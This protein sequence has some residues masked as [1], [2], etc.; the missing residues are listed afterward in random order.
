VHEATDQERADKIRGLSRDKATTLYNTFHT[1]PNFILP[2]YHYLF[3]VRTLYQ[4][5]KLDIGSLNCWIRSVEDAQQALIHHESQLQLH[6]S[7]FFALV[8]AAGH[9][10][11]SITTDSSDLDFTTQSHFS[12][13]DT[14]TTLDPAT[15]V[16]T[17]TT[18][19][20]SSTHSYMSHTAITQNTENS[21]HSNNTPP[22]SLVGALV[23]H[24]AFHRFSTSE[25]FRFLQ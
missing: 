15:V 20:I 11:K 24:L 16:T 10:S 19:T 5:L 1:N 3:T 7:R 2:C 23:R 14:I 4:R 25:I 21:V 22:P 9:K 6:S 17:T 8:F 18:D 13:D 12:D